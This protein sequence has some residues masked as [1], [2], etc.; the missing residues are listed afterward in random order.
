[1][2]TDFENPCHDMFFYDACDFRYILTSSFEVSR[3][4][5]I[6][7]NNLSTVKILIQIAN[8]DLVLTICQD[9]S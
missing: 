5:R 7:L 8:I 6:K 3:D 9:L 1:M 4:T 2:F